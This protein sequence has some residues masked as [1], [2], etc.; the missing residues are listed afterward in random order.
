MARYHLVLTLTLICHGKGGLGAP[1]HCGRDTCLEERKPD[2]RH[3]FDS[4]T[5]ISPFV[6][7]KEE[8][9]RGT[10]IDSVHTQQSV[11]FHALQCTSL[12]GN[13]QYI[14]YFAPYFQVGVA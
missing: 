7:W 12:P 9:R 5:T 3:G 10:C 14:N 1:G 11:Q 2:A 6:S 13:H 8:A 4:Y